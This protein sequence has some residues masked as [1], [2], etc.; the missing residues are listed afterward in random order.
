MYLPA[1][2]ASSLT[3]QMVLISPSALQAALAKDQR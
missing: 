1:I 2:S 3:Q